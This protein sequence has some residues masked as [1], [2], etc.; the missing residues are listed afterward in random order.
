[1]MCPM[2]RDSKRSVTISGH[3][4]SLSLENEF[5]TELR[6]AARA[7][8]VSLAALLK[9]IDAARAGTGRNL[10]SAARIYV[11]NRLKSR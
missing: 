11:L 8:G 7:E 9:R 1:M 5:W 3:R 6:A 2:P 4:T 10:S